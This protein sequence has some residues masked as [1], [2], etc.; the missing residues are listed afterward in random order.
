MIGQRGRLG[1]A[2]RQCGHGGLRKQG[3]QTQIAAPALFDRQQ[4]VHRRQRITAETE[5][6]RIHRNWHFTPECLGKQQRQF[7]F[8]RRARCQSSDLMLWWFRQG[9]AIK[10]AV[11]GHGPVVHA[12][13][14]RGHHVVRHTRGQ[15]AAQRYG[16]GK[17]RWHIGHQ[18]GIAGRVL[19][20]QHFHPLHA[21]QLAQCRL[22]LAQLDTQ[23]A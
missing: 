21:R 10:L 23:A 5:E 13:K 4:Q 22:D 17:R 18:P 20:Q 19:A 14:R 16:I 1:N 8:Q 7:L 3:P 11:G 2:N 9:V 12:D 15:V 6:I